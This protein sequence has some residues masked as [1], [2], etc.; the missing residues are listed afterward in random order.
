MA[1]RFRRR[2]EMVEA[3]L[4]TDKKNDPA[5]ARLTSSGPVRGQRPLRRCP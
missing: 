2:V 4:N 1:A 3:I 5:V